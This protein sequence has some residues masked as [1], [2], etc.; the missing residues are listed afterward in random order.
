M[1]RD[2]REEGVRVECR[3]SSGSPSEEILETARTWNAEMIVLSSHGRGESVS[4]GLGGTAH[5][6]TSAASA[7][8]LLVRIPPGSTEP[9]EFRGVE[10]ILVPVDGSPRAE[11]A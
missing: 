2:V 4:F 5:K 7:S 11:W 9:A 3:V 1:A 8:V 6:V 10:R